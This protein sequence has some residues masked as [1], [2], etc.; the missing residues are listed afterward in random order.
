MGST[1]FRNLIF[2]LRILFILLIKKLEYLNKPK[3]PT[4]TTIDD[5]RKYLEYTLPL[6][7][8]ISKPCIYPLNA[9]K[10]INKQYT[11][12]PTK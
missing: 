12:S 10:I 2:N 4:L 9:E 8:S 5:M 6:Y 7:F 3:S 1:N 11:G